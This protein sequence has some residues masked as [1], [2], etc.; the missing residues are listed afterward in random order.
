MDWVL[1]KTILT[2]SECCSAVAAAQPVGR[3][4]SLPL[5]ARKRCF[6]VLLGLCLNQLFSEGVP[7]IPHNRNHWCGHISASSGA[8]WLVSPWLSLENYWNFRSKKAFRYP[9]LIWWVRIL[10]PLRDSDLLKGTH[11]S[12]DRA[13]TGAQ[14]SWFP[15]PNVPTVPHL[16]LPEGPFQPRRLRMEMSQAWDISVPRNGQRRWRK[17]KKLSAEE[18][19]RSWGGV[20]HSVGD[21]DAQGK[22]LRCLS[23]M[24]IHE[25][26]SYQMPQGDSLRSRCLK[27]QGKNHGMFSIAQNLFL[28]SCKMSH[29]TTIQAIVSTIFFFLL[30]YYIVF[31]VFRRVRMWN[32]VSFTRLQGHRG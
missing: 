7:D 2:R 9:L 3:F 20:M 15:S 5:A 29:K 28:T 4:S 8:V 13:E 11:W 32:A 24:P 18:G 19:M 12:R 6:M 22:C 30:L 14:L 31:S 21:I 26:L 16:P 17:E 1:S 25:T 10:L 27:G 23:A